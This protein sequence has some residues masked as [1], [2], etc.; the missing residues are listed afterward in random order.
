V[1]TFSIE[2]IDQIKSGSEKAFRVVYDLYFLRLERFAAGYVIDRVEAQ[3]IVQSVFLTLWDRK[4]SLY[5]ETNLNNYLV[6]LTKNQ[7]LNYLRHVRAEL[8][9]VAKQ[10]QKNAGL[11]L[12]YYALE[13]L[14]ENKILF[15]E[16]EI[17]AKQAI[18]SL[19]GQSREV[20]ILSRIEGMKY[21]EIALKLEISVKTVEKKMSIAL[22]L[23]R[24]A[25]KDYYLLLILFLL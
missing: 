19:P 5:P 4:E 1:E 8:K 13:K 3:D 2:V 11:L 24:K 12:N 23:L 14:N 15:D 6:T 17:A 18:D 16:L 7:C 25:L 20:F 10:E 21:Q 22:E 9:Y